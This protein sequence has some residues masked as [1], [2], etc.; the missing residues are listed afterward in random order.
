LIY[1]CSSDMW[2]GTARNVQ[3]AATTPGGAIPYR[4]HFQGANILDAVIKTL[5]QAPGGQA[6]TYLNAER[7]TVTMPDLDGATH[8]LFSRTS[9]G[10]G[11]VR[12]HADRLR[13]NLRQ[14]NLNCQPGNCPLDFRAVIDAGYGPRFEALNYASYVECPPLCSYDALMQ[15][16]WN[17]VTLGL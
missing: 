16:Q 2:S 14:H 3:L 6:V 10:S 13:E 4:I 17:N 11:G 9:A 15:N 5:R 7:E 12:H 8:V 1:Y